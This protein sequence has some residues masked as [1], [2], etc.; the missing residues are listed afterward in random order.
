MCRLTTKEKIHQKLSGKYIRQLLK[1]MVQRKAFPTTGRKQSAKDS[2]G[3]VRP[4]ARRS[5]SSSPLRQPR[6]NLFIDLSLHFSH[7]RESCFQS[8]WVYEYMMPSVKILSL[9]S[10]LR[11]HSFRGSLGLTMEEA[12]IIN[13]FVLMDHS[14]SLWKLCL[15]IAKTNISRWYNNNIL[16]SVSHQDAKHKF[17][18]IPRINQHESCEQ[19]SRKGALLLLFKPSLIR[20]KE[21][22][23]GLTMYFSWFFLHHF[24]DILLKTY[25][26]AE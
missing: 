6:V 2:G 18:Q 9:N 17:S 4:R 12:A 20:L 13:P 15:I 16:F 1:W 3:I 7:L 11:H 25:V 8:T 26:H 21:K 10:H 22:N 14:R 5:E 19:G 24:L 23:S